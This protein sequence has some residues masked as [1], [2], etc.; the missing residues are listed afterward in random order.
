MSGENQTQNA[1]CLGKLTLRE[2]AWGKPNS[3]CPLPGKNTLTP[4]RE[5]ILPFIYYSNIDFEL[6]L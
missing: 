3:K 4:R 1:H 5:I 6:E 2:N